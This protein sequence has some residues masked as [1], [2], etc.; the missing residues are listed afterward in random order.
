[1]QIDRQ[2]HPGHPSLHDEEEGDEAR[3]VA[4]VNWRRKHRDEADQRVE[5]EQPEADP[6]NAEVV[7]DMQPGDP[8]D[9]FDE[10]VAVRPRI[11]GVGE[12]SGQYEDGRC[13]H[14][15]EPLSEPVREGGDED[16]A[17]D[18]DEPDR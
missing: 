1:M 8:L 12:V 13:D 9:A 6:V 14:H 4:H 10:L 11:E 3:R 17:G 18:G 5:D 2:K 15:A 7:I 16:A